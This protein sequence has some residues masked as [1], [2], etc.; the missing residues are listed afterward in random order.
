MHEA[1]LVERGKAQGAVTIRLT[2]MLPPITV[3][4]HKKEPQGILRGEV[5]PY[6]QVKE[7]TQ[8]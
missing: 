7:L 1:N 8:R 6:V 4:C 2:N 5:W 3:R